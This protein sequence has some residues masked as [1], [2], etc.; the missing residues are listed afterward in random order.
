MSFPNDVA[1]AICHGSYHSPKLYE[2][3]MD[4]LK[5][6]GMTPYCPYLPTADLSKLNVGDI[7]HPNFDR[8]AP[9]GGY[10]QKG[11]WTA[12]WHHC[13]FQP[14]GGTIFVQ[15]FMEFHASTIGRKHGV[16]GLSTIVDVEEFFFND[17]NPKEAKEWATTLTGSPIL[18]TNLTKRCVRHFAL[19]LSD[20]RG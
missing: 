6:V 5:D 12:G 20:P 17:K 2:P 9:T 11:Q 14:K 3:L 7:D 15:A 10:P 8:A 4:A 18:T 16:A 19:R 13:L 1:V